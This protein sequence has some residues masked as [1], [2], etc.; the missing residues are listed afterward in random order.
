EG[1]VFVHCKAG[2]SRTAAAAGA[3]LVLKQGLSAEEA[4]RRMREARPGMIIR[5]EVVR[6]LTRVEAETG[7]QGERPRS[8]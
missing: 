3:W 5:P 7:S 2:Y 6:A 8:A 4:V 1:I